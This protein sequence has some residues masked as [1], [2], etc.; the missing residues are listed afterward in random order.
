MDQNDL[1][2]D[3]AKFDPRNVPQNT[4]EVNQKL[5]KIGGSI[6]KWYEVS[7]VQELGQF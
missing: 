6:S 7:R 2:L 4:I 5:I 1:R 3:A